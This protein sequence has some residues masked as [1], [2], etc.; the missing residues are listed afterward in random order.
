[1]LLPPLL[2]LL[3]PALAAAQDTVTCECAL[4]YPGQ[5]EADTDSVPL[6]W[7][8]TPNLD[9]AMCDREDTEPNA[10]RG[11]CFN[12]FNNEGEDKNVC[13]NKTDTTLQ[14]CYGSLWC[15]SLH[16]QGFPELNEAEVGL[17]YRMPDCPEGGTPDYTQW[18]RVRGPDDSE[19]STSEPVCCEDG[20]F[21]SCGEPCPG[22]VQTNLCECGFFADEQFNL[23]PEG[24]NA[25]PLE[26]LGR[27][28]SAPDNE[29]I[30][31]D[32]PSSD[33]RHPCDVMCSNRG[34]DF[35]SSMRLDQMKPQSVRRYGEAYCDALY[36]RWEQNWPEDGIVAASLVV[37][38]RM[39]GCGD[40]DNLKW[41]TPRTY[42]THTQKLCCDKDGA[43]NWC[44]E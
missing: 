1:M 30:C 31:E 12:I 13:A 14:R 42:A 24:T 44:L 10:C 4:F 36:A 3:L 2:A 35:V 39:P 33:F 38:G 18:T 21:E 7:I 20:I 43:W 34:Q 41:F 19:V 8:G 40:D 17:F 9:P 11:R 26:Q 28:F 6:E 37:H 5:L 32:W 16:N 25:L 22:C 23:V 27:I 29:P 15:E